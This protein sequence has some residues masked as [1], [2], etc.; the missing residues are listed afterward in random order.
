MI[1]YL[2]VHT[3]YIL[4]RSHAGDDL[5]GTHD[6]P[7]TAARATASASLWISYLVSSKRVKATFVA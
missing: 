5:M 3:I 7:A 6:F 2:G 4:I 1:V